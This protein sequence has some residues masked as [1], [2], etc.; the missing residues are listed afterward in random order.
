MER[1]KKAAEIESIRRLFSNN[2][3]VQKQAEDDLKQAWD[4]YQPAFRVD[5]LAVS[6]PQSCA[7]MAA[8]R[9][10]VREVIDWLISLQ[11]KL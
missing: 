11:P 8:K 2:P 1:N 4:Y 7:L 6:D 5:E 10:S 9:D 3:E